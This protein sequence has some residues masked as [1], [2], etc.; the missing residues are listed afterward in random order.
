MSEIM[1]SSET[2]K[3]AAPVKEKAAAAVV[4][5]APVET[6][7]KATAEETKK[8]AAD[9]AEKKPAAKAPAKKTAE[10]K[11]AAAKAASKTAVKTR[12]IFQHYGEEF[13][14]EAIMKKVQKAAQKKT[15]K[16]KK[17]E[18]YVNIE[19]KAVYY[20]VNGEAGEDNRIQ[21]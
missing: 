1:R 19:E 10:K 6:E 13:D 3:N 17:L 18:A 9:K 7:K 5:S 2:K 12:I 15:D 11:P 8:A 16:L 14:P 20:V 21:L 4:K